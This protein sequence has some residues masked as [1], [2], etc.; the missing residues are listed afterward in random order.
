M[1]RAGGRGSGL[2]RVTP[3]QE[4]YFRIGWTGEWVN[5]RRLPER[6]AFKNRVSVSL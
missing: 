2:G 3:P 5:D 1:A 6:V 4:E